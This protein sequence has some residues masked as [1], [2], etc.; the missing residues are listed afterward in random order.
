[1]MMNPFTEALRVLDERGWYQ[2]EVEGPDGRGLCAV[3]ALMEAA[4]G[5]GW[6]ASLW[7]ERTFGLRETSGLVGLA[8]FNDD[9]STTEEDVRLLFKHAVVAWDEEHS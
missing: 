3:G 4:P 6:E 8:A 9:P 2:G 7:V 1:M 5:H